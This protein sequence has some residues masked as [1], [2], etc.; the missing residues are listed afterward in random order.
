MLPAKYQSSEFL[1]TANQNRITFA[2]EILLMMSAGMSM[3]NKDIPIEIM[4]MVANE[5]MS[6]LT[7][8]KLI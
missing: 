8:T 3:H 1:G 5:I 6:K 7:G 2:G 4:L